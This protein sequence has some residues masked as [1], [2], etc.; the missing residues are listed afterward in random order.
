MRFD[1]TMTISMSVTEFDGRRGLINPARLITCIRR[2]A[3]VPALGFDGP[4]ALS[5]LS[6]C[7]SPCLYR[8]GCVP[9]PSSERRRVPL[10]SR[11][12]GKS[13]RL[14]LTLILPPSRRHTGQDHRLSPAAGL[15]PMHNAGIPFQPPSVSDQLHRPAVTTPGW[16]PFALA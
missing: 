13:P 2:W 9:D 11:D 7:S 10:P 8:V 3:I 1:N 16:I 12:L 4:C 5:Y 14:H 15:P 6:P